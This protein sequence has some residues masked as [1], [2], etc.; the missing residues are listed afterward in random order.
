[1]SVNVNEHVIELQVPVDDAPLVQVPQ[2]QD[3]LGR[4]EPGMV[5]GQLPLLLHVKHQVAALHELDHEEQSETGTRGQLLID[6]F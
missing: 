1:M 4:E 3:D 6:N 5:L 2:G